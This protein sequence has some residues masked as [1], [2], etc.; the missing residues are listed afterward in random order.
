MHLPCL[1]HSEAFFW[2]IAPARAPAHPSTPPR[3][4]SGNLLVTQYGLSTYIDH[5]TVT[6]QELPETA[7]PGQLPRSGGWGV[8]GG[9]ACSRQRAGL[10]R[11]AGSCPRL[12]LCPAAGTRHRRSLLASGEPLWHAVGLQLPTCKAPAVPFPS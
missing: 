6:I 4:E 10:R 12:C 3:D 1:H 11:A 2:F 5:Q 8:R 7:P 9:D